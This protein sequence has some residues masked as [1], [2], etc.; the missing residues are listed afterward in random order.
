MKKLQRKMKL[1][2]QEFRNNVLN[3]QLD[4]SL[5]TLATKK[6]FHY[7]DSMFLKYLWSWA[8][9][10]HPN[11]SKNWIQKKYF[12]FLHSKKWFFGKRVGKSFICLPLHSQTKI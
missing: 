5:T 12:H 1:W 4:S 11:K 6:T 3:C 8:R 2:C 9:K 10:T 7:C